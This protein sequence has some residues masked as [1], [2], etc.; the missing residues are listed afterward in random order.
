MKA[1]S[2]PPATAWAVCHAGRR[3][4]VCSM[5]SAPTHR[6]TLLIHATKS[7]ERV[8]FDSAVDAIVS[9]AGLSHPPEN[10][11]ETFYRRG[12]DCG[13]IWMPAPGL[14][15]GAIVARAQLADVVQTTTNGHRVHTSGLGCDRCL[16]C[17]RDSLEWPE[18]RCKRADPWAKSGALGLVLDDIEVLL[19][20]IQCRG[21]AGLFNV[22]D[23]LL[24]G[25]A[26]QKDGR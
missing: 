12:E 8:E 3:I 4:V 5:R 24:D 21:G 14:P 15:R 11:A 1:F 25:A 18:L 17:N 23:S 6:G 2:V 22:D 10:L 9:T 13:G 26:F 16:L 20:P 19:E 7:C